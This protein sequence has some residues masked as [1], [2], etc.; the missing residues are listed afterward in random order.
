MDIGGES[1]TETDAIG[2]LTFLVI[3][4]TTHNLLGES[5]TETDA[6]ALATMSL[7]ATGE[8]YTESDSVGYASL[9]MDIGGE[10]YTETYAESLLGMS[11]KLLGE[12]YT[13]ASA[14]GFLS[15]TTAIY[16]AQ[17]AVVAGYSYV[18]GSVGETQPEHLLNPSPLFAALRSG[19]TFS[20]AIAVAMPTINSTWRPIGDPLGVVPMP[21]EGFEIR[22]QPGMELV[23]VE[24]GDATQVDLG[25][26]LTDGEWDVD[27]IR[28]D[29]YGSSSDPATI[30]VKIESS[31]AVTQLVE[32][33]RVKSK[34]QSGGMVQVQWASIS[35]DSLDDSA[36]FEIA[37]ASDP[38]TIL[39]TITAGSA[40]V[41]RVSVGPFTHGRTVRLLIRATDGA[42]TVGPWVDV[43]PF[44]SDSQPPP[45]PEFV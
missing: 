9:I 19:W 45:L 7:S 15:F 23:S 36:A 33:A 27:I 12:S 8:S 32:P 42:G 18:V 25:G 1:Y 13:Q 4:G 17:E 3:G 24:L 5:Y 10:S 16:L 31:A 38:A 28:Q 37:A 30:R 35:D 6:A 40:S 44:V 29:K 39:N 26:L 21:R 2:N 41:F 43:P 11:H 14:N 22:K 20:E 34:T